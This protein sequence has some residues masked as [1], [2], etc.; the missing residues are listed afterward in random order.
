MASVSVKD[1]CVVMND[2]VC[3]KG[4]LPVPVL[5]PVPKVLPDE[6]ALML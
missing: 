3:V 1:C 4:P 6:V 2:E 5:V